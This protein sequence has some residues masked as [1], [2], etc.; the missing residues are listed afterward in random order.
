[1]TDL[2]FVLPEQVD[3]FE[4]H[5]VLNRE[6]VTMDELRALHLPSATIQ[7]LLAI[8]SAASEFAACIVA[9]LSVSRS[10]FARFTAC[11]ALVNRDYLRFQACCA[12]VAGSV[13]TGN[14][15]AAQFRV[16]MG[17]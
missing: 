6:A 9:L 8:Q 1:M 3:L 13:P 5:A 2:F 11:V 12:D 16:D 14:D 10:L 4:L 15:G 17:E 7:K